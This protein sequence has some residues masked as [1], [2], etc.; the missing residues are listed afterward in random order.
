MQPGNS[1]TAPRCLARLAPLAGAVLGLFGLTAGAAHAAFA[2]NYVS[3]C[4]DSGAGSLR[5]T[6]AA[7]AEG[8]I[9]DF[10]GLSDCTISVTTGAIPIFDANLTIRGNPGVP[11][12]G[13]GNA[14]GNA[15][16]SQSTGGGV[17]YIEN[18]TMGHNHNEGTTATGGC[19]ATEGSTAIYYSTITDCIAHGTSGPA[20]GGAIAATGYVVLNHVNI[21]ASEANPGPKQLAGGGA[22]S[23]NGRFGA[24]YSTISG[25]AADR[26]GV[27]YGFGGA[28]YARGGVLLSHTTIASNQ[29]S[30][31]VGGVLAAGGPEVDIIESTI[32]GNS[33]QVGG[34]LY[35]IEVPKVQIDNST[36]A[37]N[38]D[39][40]TRSVPAG[41]V[42]SVGT[43]SPTSVVL[44]MH[45]SIVSNNYIGAYDWDFAGFEDATHKVTFEASSS[46]N[47]IRVAGFSAVP[48]DT[49]TA[50]PLLGPL[51]DNGGFSPT[52]ALYSGSPAIDAGSNPNMDP[53]DQRFYDLNAD[54]E[55]VRESPT[56]LPDI[57]AYEIDKSEIIFTAGNEGCVTLP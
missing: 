54:H 34:G 48:A 50:C 3:T 30:L 56:G 2:V 25:N 7:A 51:R 18:V 38:T 8:D 14:P 26:H 46:N 28:V 33:A 10:S 9:V 11:I 32:S 44:K 20:T 49:S 37:F 43:S 21:S 13:S 57:G 45:S 55:F 53:R 52:H 17:L 5:D 41:V 39:Q 12:D 36:I 29:A 47:L 6:I 16:L 24:S 22:V 27:G 42:V 1:I 40:A 4:D 31:M 15:L 19:L 23:A 35:T